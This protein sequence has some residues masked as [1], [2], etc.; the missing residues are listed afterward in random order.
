MVNAHPTHLSTLSLSHIYLATCY[1]YI[2]L[3]A[4]LRI[5]SIGPALERSESG[6]VNYNEKSLRIARNN[7][8]IIIIIIYL[9]RG[10][11]GF[12]GKEW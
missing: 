11:K 10:E 9:L 2:K 8:V 1:W 3:V 6:S 4:D 12:R 7:S 5:T